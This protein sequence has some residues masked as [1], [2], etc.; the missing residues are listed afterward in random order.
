[1]TSELSRATIPPYHQST[2]P[3]FILYL[4][5][6]PYLSLC[7]STGFTLCWYV[8]RIARQ[9]L[10]LPGQN[11][12][13]YLSPIFPGFTVSV[14]FP[15][16]FLSSPNTIFLLALWQLTICKTGGGESC[17][18]SLGIFFGSFTIIYCG[19]ASSQLPRLRTLFLT[20]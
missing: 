4:Q 19:T 20:F 11:F 1:M 16:L 7:T 15:S 13:F 9:R 12:G 18:S 6:P 17:I 8:S 5:P 2:L 14:V 10:G 3:A